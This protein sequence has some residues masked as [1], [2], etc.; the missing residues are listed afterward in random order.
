MNKVCCMVCWKK[1][2]QTCAFQYG[3]VLEYR[4]FP[5]AY[6]DAWLVLLAGVYIIRAY[7]FFVAYAFAVP[8]T[9]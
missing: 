1:Q 8:K 4:C 3:E 6:Q 7:S 9:G 2:L 5:R